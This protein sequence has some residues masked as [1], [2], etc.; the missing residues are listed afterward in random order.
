MAEMVPKKLFL[1]TITILLAISS[2]GGLNS[3][4]DLEES[5]IDGKSPDNDK[6]LE[7]MID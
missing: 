4:Q 7:N 1:L 6:D 2:A 3:Y 5:F